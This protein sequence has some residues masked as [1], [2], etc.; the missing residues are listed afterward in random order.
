LDDRGT[1]LGFQQVQAIFRS[2]V[3]SR[4]AVPTQVYM[5][6]FLLPLRES[7]LSPSSRV[8]VKNVWSYSCTLQY[9]FMVW[10]WIQHRSNF[11]L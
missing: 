8:E 4:P 7:D 6:S 10:C 3:T 2:P 11:A 1:G 9:A 5:R